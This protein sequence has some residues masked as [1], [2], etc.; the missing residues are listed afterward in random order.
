MTTMLSNV[1]NGVKGFLAFSIGLSSIPI[2]IGKVVYPL[3]LVIGVFDIII[4]IMLLVDTGLT[5]KLIKQLS[6]Q[7]DR[8]NQENL[9]FSQN[10][11]TLELQLENLEQDIK[12]IQNLNEDYG[13]HNQDLAEEVGDLST[14]ND[15]LEINI[16]NLIKQVD[17]MKIVQ[18]QSKQ[19][20]AALMNMG[21]DFSEFSETLIGE[22]DRIENISDAM[23]ILLNKLA[24]DK[25]Q[26][27]DLDGNGTL[28]Q[29]ELLKWA[30]NHK[31]ID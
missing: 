20:I 3:N 11:H 30:K 31:S 24:Y 25:F 9:D 18:N 14:H 19:L 15:S 23:D 22:V 1:Y 5:S 28:T 29:D 2:I 10:N 12:L 27:I 16:G 13:Q 26:E 7:I 6:S 4:A 21:D 17:G 8:L